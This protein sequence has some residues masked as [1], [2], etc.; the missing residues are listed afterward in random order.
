MQGKVS[1]LI[2][3]GRELKDPVLCWACIGLKKKG[4]SESQGVN[5]NNVMNETSI[6]LE[7]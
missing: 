6:H 4:N 7:L 3:H 5:L 1:S 2:F